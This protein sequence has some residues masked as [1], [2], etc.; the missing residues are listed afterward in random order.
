VTVVSFLSTFFILVA[1]IPPGL[2][3]STQE[4]R[5]VSVPEYFEGIDLQYFA[6]TYC[7]NLTNPTGVES[8]EFDFGGKHMEVWDSAGDKWIGIFTESHWWV[9]KWEQDSFHWRDKDGVDRSVRSVY[10]YAQ[11]INWFMSY[12]VLDDAYASFGKDGLK[13]NLKNDHAEM[14]VYVGW[15]QTKYAKPS[16]ALNGGELSLLLCM[17][18][19]QINTTF[20]AWN[21]IGS[22]LFFQMPNVH[23][24]LNALI[25]IPIWVMIA[26][27]IYILILKAIPFVGG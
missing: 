12:Q 21:I 2:V 20:N 26:W 15:N 13:W 14:T 25:A 10:W 7:V 6:Q 22:I 5:I 3:P 18:F 16:D 17:N 1:T 9:F 24:A 8:Y 4:G 19:D 23:P 11:Q 27:L